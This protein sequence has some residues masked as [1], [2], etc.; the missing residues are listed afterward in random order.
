MSTET[1][2]E[3]KG[4]KALL[5]TRR[6]Q[7]RKSPD[8]F[9]DPGF[10]LVELSGIEP[11]TSTLQVLSVADLRALKKDLATLRHKAAQRKPPRIVDISPE[12]L[13]AVTRIR[14]AML[15]SKAITPGLTPEIARRIAVI[16]AKHSG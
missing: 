10:C 16:E 15:D 5:K 6:R 4:V 14:V 13:A 2:L 3:L 7:K 9:R 1:E 11:L 12:D 8:L